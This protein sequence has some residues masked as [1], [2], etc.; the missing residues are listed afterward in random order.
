M[1]TE[2]YIP[3]KYIT[4]ADV[5]DYVGIDEKLQKSITENERK[6]Y[7]GWVREANNIVETGLFPDSDVIPLEFGSAVYTYARSAALNWVLYKKRDYTGSRN[8]VNAKSDFQMDLKLAQNY[9]KR[10]P[11]QKNEPIQETEVTNFE[12]SFIIPY[13]QTQGYPP[14]ILY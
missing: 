12:N 6:R 13:S 9:L 8:A 14:D 11:T 7:Q 4:T 5:F 3:D 10:T 1:S 2:A